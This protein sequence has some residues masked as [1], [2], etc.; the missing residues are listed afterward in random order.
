M[1]ALGSRFVNSKTSLESGKKAPAVGSLS[2]I[3]ELRHAAPEKLRLAHRMRKPDAQ[4]RLL[5]ERNP[6]PMWVFDRSTLRF[7]AVNEA[8]VRNYGYSEQEFLSMTISEIR[9]EAEI[10]TLVKH[11]SKH[12][13]GLQAPEPWRHRRKDGSILEVEIVGYDL[14]FHGVDAMLVAAHDVTERNRAQ[15]AARSA[16]EKYRSIFNNAVV[17]IFRVTPEG[18]PISVNAAMAKIHGYDTPEDLLANVS[19]AAAQLFVD[20][21]RMVELHGA[22]LTGEVQRAELEIFRADRS[23]KWIAISLRATRDA[24]GKVQ[25]LEGT[26]EDINQRKMA[27]EALIYKSALLEAESETT[28]DGIL[29]VDRSGKIVL[30][31]QQFGRYF[32][33][34]REWIE[35]QDDSLVLKHTTNLMENP[36]AF[37]DKVR[38]L[39]RHP[40]ERSRDELALKD[41]R[42]FDRYSAPL[43]DP[44]GYYHGRI[45]YFRDISDRKTADARIQHLAYYDALTD[46]PNRTLLNDRLNVALA[47]ARSRGG[48]VALLF[49]D[50]DRFTIIN[51]SLG[52]SFG[53]QVLK[54]VA[55]RLKQALRV[56]DTVARIGGDE[57]V[58]L[59]DSIQDLAETAITAGR[60][61]ASMAQPFEIQGQAVSTTFS[62]GITIAPEHGSDP[63]SLIKKAEAAM[64]CAKEEGRNA[65]RLFSEEIS[66]KAFRELIVENAL[67]TALPKG[68]LFLLYQP[69]MDV[70]NGKIIGAEALLRWRHPELGLVPPDQFIR[71]AENSGLILPIGEWVLRTACAQIAQWRA[72]GLSVVPVAVN[73][74]AVQLRTENFCALTKEVLRET[75]VPPE[76]LELELTE[77]LMVANPGQSNSMLRELAAMGLKLAID[78]FGTGYSSLSYLKQLRVNKLKIDRSFV[79]DLSSDADD[80]AIATAIISMAKSL[81]LRV[82]AEGVETEEQISFLRERQCDEIQ[83]YYFGM[84]MTPQEMALKFAPSPRWINHNDC[85]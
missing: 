66:G 83:G 52:R 85:A 54:N 35:S 64:H 19:D 37:L 24:A 10:P 46:L 71:I 31:N 62:I 36:D 30:A 14:V 33:V 57:F 80:A 34:P 5:F 79:R 26:V 49:L 75:G 53:D 56:Q 40:I 38:Y 9:P 16:E 51:E 4:Y 84:P 17:G 6:I 81:G 77:S 73:V 7:L 28:L 55:L 45:W 68:E 74:S 42:T 3:I 63:E 1:A 39:Y 41:G 82:L 60:L 8:A 32:G 11:V 58:I 22:A 44:A 76:L 65:F 61:I 72:Q 59:L 27:E 21:S 23:R 78:D 13:N 47:R 18:R 29:V 48:Q 20:P 69:Q 2:E 67:R 43:I 12:E 25:F 70:A 15:E 50:L